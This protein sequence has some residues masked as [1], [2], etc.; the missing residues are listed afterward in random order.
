MKEKTKPEDE[1][2][3]GCI[4]FGVIVWIIYGMVLFL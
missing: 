2:L 1:E 3:F 4:I